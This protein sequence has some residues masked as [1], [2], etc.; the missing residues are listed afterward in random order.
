MFTP[1]WDICITTFPSQVASLW[2]RKLKDCKARVGGD[3][4]EMVFHNRTGVCMNA[5]LLWQH[6]QELSKVGTDKILID[7]AIRELNWFLNWAQ[8]IQ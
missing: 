4:K 1:K 6:V 2:K 8:N 5:Q 7:T 3:Y